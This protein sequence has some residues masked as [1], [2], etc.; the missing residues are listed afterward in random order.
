M[1]FSDGANVEAFIV[2][3]MTR[4]RTCGFMNLE[5][6]NQRKISDVHHVF[7]VLR[8]QEAVISVVAGL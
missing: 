1:C 6:I 3:G 5:T 4:C 8:L 2:T 7:D